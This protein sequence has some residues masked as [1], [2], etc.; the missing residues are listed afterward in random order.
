MGGNRWNPNANINRDTVYKFNGSPPPKR[1][2][3]LAPP[4][5][6]RGSVLI[7]LQPVDLQNSSSVKP[8]PTKAVID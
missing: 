2:S 3:I 4:R 1:G 5:K 7:N 6:W 8:D